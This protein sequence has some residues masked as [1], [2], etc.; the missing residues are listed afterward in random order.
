MA[1]MGTNK[2]CPVAADASSRGKSGPTAVATL[3]PSLTLAV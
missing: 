2:T 3:R 1:V